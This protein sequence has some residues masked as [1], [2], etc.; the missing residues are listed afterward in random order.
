MSTTS[1]MLYPYNM[2][3][4]ILPIIIIALLSSCTVTEELTLGEGGSGESVM[5]LHAEDFFIDVL[6]DFS[7]FLPENNETIM[8][9]TVRGFA[10][11]F[12]KNGEITSSSWEKLGENDYTFSFAY[13]DL[14]ALLQSVG[15]ENQTLFRE[16]ENTLSF[17]LDMENYQELKQL[18]PLLSDPNF[19]VYGPE[20]NQGMSE[21]DYLDMIYFLLGEDGPEAIANGL[22]TV[23][24]TVPGTITEAENCA[25]LDEDTASY[26]FPIIDFLLL[27]QPMEFSISWN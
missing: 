14:D 3:K 27:N 12:G 21:A 24:I 1:L 10:E 26:S 15:A 23:N 13:S 4:I 6:N 17:H 16:T 18:I 11:E 19:E 5:T 7:E 20:Y 8:D 25:L 2:K 22:V 9:S